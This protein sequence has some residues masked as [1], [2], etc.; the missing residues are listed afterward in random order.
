MDV[1]LFFTRKGEVGDPAL[2]SN[3][4]FAVARAADQLAEAIAL[5]NQYA[6]T[7]VAPVAPPNKT[8]MAA[9]EAAHPAFDGRRTRR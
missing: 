9:D 7:H 5:L 6:N 3:I 1:G 8:T 2:P 4:A